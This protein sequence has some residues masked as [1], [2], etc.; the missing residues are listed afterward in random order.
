MSYFSDS[1]TKN[2]LIILYVLRELGAELTREQLTTLSGERELMPYFDLQNAISELEEEGLLAAVPRVF[3]QAYSLTSRGR[4][5]IDMFAERLPLSLREELQEY[6]ALSGD[7]VLR[8]AQ[9]SSGMEKLPSGAYQIT[10][11]ALEGDNE[12]VS[13]KLLLPDVEIARSACKQWK[14]RAGDIYRFVFASLLDC[15]QKST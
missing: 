3:G 15:S 11:K 12:I 1:F 6:V 4:E 2:K 5:T 8:S 7:K 9:Y 14:N 13:L 10:L